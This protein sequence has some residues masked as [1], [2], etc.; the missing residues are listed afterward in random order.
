MSKFVLLRSEHKNEL[1]RMDSIDKINIETETDR[2]VI[3]CIN[4]FINDEHWEAFNG[5]EVNGNLEYEL[6]VAIL[7]DIATELHSGCSIDL[8][9]LIK[10]CIK[11]IE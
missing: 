4:V 1:L 2:G 3:G 7:G 6:Q 8:D 11:Y 9:S 10:N 5:G